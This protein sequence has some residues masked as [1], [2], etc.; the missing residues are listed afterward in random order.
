MA[1]GGWPNRGRHE[2][3]IVKQL[4][5]EQRELVSVLAMR[6][7]A[8]RGIRAVVLGGSHARGRAQ[9]GSDIDLGILY[10]EV[11]PFSIQSVRELVEDVNEGTRSRGELGA[12]LP[13]QKWILGTAIAP[14]HLSRSPLYCW[15]NADSLW[16]PS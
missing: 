13:C 2:G 12:P 7:G 4:S 1:E 3:F 11:A 15:G 5:P 16:R 6:L 10:S 8:V 14:A 9:P